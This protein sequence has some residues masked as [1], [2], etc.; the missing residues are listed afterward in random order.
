MKNHDDN[1]FQI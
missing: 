1:Q